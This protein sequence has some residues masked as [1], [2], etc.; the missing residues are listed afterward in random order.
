M[1]KNYKF[2]GDSRDPQQWDPLMGSFP[3]YSH[4]TPIRIPKDMGMVWEAYHKGGPIG[5]GPWKIP[6]Q[7][8]SFSG[9]LAF[10]LTFWEPELRKLFFQKTAETR[11]QGDMEINT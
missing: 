10:G 7:V 11:R 6:L 2:K 5:G 1:M 4:T 3:Y 9:W 8:V